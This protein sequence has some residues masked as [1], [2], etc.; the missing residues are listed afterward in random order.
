MLTCNEVLVEIYKHKLPIYIDLRAKALIDIVCINEIVLTEFLDTVF[1]KNLSTVTLSRAKRILAIPRE[2]VIQLGKLGYIKEFITKPSIRSYTGESIA[3]FL[4]S[5]V[6]IEH[7]AESHNACSSK[8]IKH[9][10][11]H[12]IT[13]ELAPFIFTKSEELINALQSPLLRNAQAHEQLG[14]FS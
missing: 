11:E 7:W 6:C 1:L 10:K 13:P 4:D 5:F 9:L 3:S 2:R 14:L 8:V 12:N